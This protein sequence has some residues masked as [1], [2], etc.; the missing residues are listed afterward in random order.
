MVLLVRIIGLR[1]FSKMTS[2]DFVITLAM[3][4]LLAGAS[5]ATEWPVFAQAMA[6]MGALFLAQWALALAR[7]RSVR[8]EKAIENEPILLMRDGKLLESALRRSRVSRDDV[9]AKLREA[10]VLSMHDVRAVVLET[11][12]DVT[13]LHGNTLEVEM[14]AGV[15]GTPL[16][17]D[18]PFEIA[19][20]NGGS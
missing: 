19:E 18:E 11:T 5:Q 3:G 4:S 12:G 10:N 15:K 17:R 7:Q 6:A 9:L 2:V 16:E 1:S 14:L 20:E 13:V 8:F